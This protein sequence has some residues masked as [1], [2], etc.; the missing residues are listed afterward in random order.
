MDRSFTDL[1][2]RLRRKTP[3]VHHI[4]NLVTARASADVALAVGASPIMAHALQEVADV[5]AFADA[6][7]LNI[8]TPTPHLVEAMVAAGQAANR[9]GIP[10]L[11]D[12]VGAGATP[13]RTEACRTL[14]DTVR[15]CAIKGNAS[16]IETLATGHG[17]GRG[18]DAGQVA[19]SIP[20]AAALLAE[21]HSCTVI[22]TGKVDVATD[23]KRSF[24]C[25]NGHELM[26]RITGGGCMAST[27]IAAFL[28]LGE[29]PLE[30]SL[31]ALS[32]FE[33]AAERAAAASSGP[34]TFQTG[35]LDEL[36][37]LPDDSWEQAVRL[38]EQ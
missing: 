29:D 28:A 2:W 12:P 23:G 16:E 11:L 36:A 34:G 17:Q 38:S 22:A 6:L 31:A 15:L 7:V 8:G 37:R 1:W 21:R 32:G 27:V 9:K 35:L 5:V 20:A 18:V 24:A 3:V 26:S 4:T 19:S 13:L 14:A 30:S 10:V 25:A 33:I